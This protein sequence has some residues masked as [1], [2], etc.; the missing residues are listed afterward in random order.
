MYPINL[1]ALALNMQ[2]AS[3][4]R[5]LAAVEGHEASLVAELRL[6]CC[7]HACLL[8]MY[9]TNLFAFATLTCRWQ[10]WSAGWLL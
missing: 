6:T 4:E 2:V 5:R 1:F 8:F 3:L 9:P 10:V 7:K